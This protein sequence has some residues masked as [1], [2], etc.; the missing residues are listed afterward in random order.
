MNKGKDL[1]PHIGIFGRRNNGKSSFINAVTGQEVAIVSE[2]PGT[3]TDPVKKSLEIFGI[4]PVI[5]IDTAGIDDTG[6]LGEKRIQKTWDTLR[7]IDCAVI[8]IAENRFDQYEQTLIGKLNEW[9]VPF[10]IAH[11]KNDLQPLKEETRQRIAGLTTAPV[12][13]FSAEKKTGLDDLIHALRNTIPDSAYQK[14]SLFQDLIRSKDIVLLITPI[15]Q[16]APD[17]RMILPQ[18]MA[19]RDVLDHDAICMSVKETELIDFF[20]LGIRPALAVTDSQAFEYVASVVPEDV[21]LTSF[22]IL[23]ARI[24]GP[25]DNYIR[26][27]E[28]LRKIKNN[29]KILI[30]ES[31]THQVNCDDIGRYK[32]PQW[33]REYTGCNPQF[34]VIAGLAPLPADLDNYALTIQCGGCMA[35]R[36][37]IINRLKPLQNAGIPITNYGMAIA[38]MKGI[39]PR[40]LKPFFTDKKVTWKLPHDQADSV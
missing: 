11:N 25:F 40:A 39:L 22:S 28:A 24:K 27:A 20:R 16:E 23:F 18:V 8:L 17:G 3:T 5:L 6:K 14:P 37:Q 9:N 19:W 12:I 15:D 38:Q 29:D 30:L 26:G 36:K 4:G 32:L 2:I 33:I 21:P 13:D 35:T 7:Q 31:C 1:K 10:I 34:E